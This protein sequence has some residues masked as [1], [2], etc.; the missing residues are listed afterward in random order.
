MRHFCAQNVQFAARKDFSLL[1]F[2]AVYIVKMKA[3]Y[4]PINE[5]LTIKEY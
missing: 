1:S 4:Q 3:R 5:I 2:T